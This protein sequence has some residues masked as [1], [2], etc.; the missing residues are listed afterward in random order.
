MPLTTMPVSRFGK[1]QYERADDRRPCNITKAALDDPGQVEM[2][3]PDI[4][5]NRPY[6]YI[7]LGTHSR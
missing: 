6:P 7:L 3:P 4:L 1:S 2:T 5:S